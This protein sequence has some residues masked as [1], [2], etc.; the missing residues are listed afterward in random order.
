LNTIRI[1]T[2]QVDGCRGS[3]GRVSTDRIL[4]VVAGGAPD[5]VALQGIDSEDNGGQ[6]ALLARQLGMTWYANQRLGANAFLSYF[7]LSALQD[8]ALGGNGTCLRADT[9]VGEK[10]LHL[11]N[12]CLDP[13]LGRRLQ[14]VNRLLGPELLGHP[15]L[16]CPTLL[17]GDFADL[18]WGAGNMN[19]ALTL[20]KARRPWWPGTDPARFPVFGRDRAYLKGE[21]RVVEASI[22]RSA[23]AR[24]AATH[25]PLILTLQL[26]DPR[27]Y[28]RAD[29][30]A[31][32]RMEV[33]TG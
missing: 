29:K 25:L 28:L 21:L 18:L 23:A 24:Q 13:R 5:I 3:D 9:T 33:A 30:L 16:V 2:Y 7:P 32:G 19:L 1:M 20:R 22:I 26:K 15:S 10:R 14:Q 17:L 12:V 8:Y 31:P 6:V 4:D 11:F 27:T